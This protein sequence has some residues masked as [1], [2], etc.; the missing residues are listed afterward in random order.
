MKSYL[1][2]SIILFLMIFSPLLVQVT[3]AQEKQEKIV[4]KIGV[5]WWLVPVIAID[6]KGNA[7]TDLKPED[8][9]VKVNQ[10]VLSNFAFLKSSFSVTEAVTEKAEPVKKTVKAPVPRNR[11]VFLLFDLSMSGKLTIQRSKRVAKTI[12][13]DS[14]PGTRFI[15]MSI[16]PF[17]GLRYI[18]ESISDHKQL[19]SQIEKE[20]RPR[21]SK[22]TVAGTDIAV[23]VVGKVARLSASELKVWASEAA[24][25]H[26]RR[27]NAFF[28]SFETLYFHLNGIEDNKFV[29]FFSEGIS[30]AIMKTLHGGASLYRDE[31]KKVAS[32]LGRCGAV[33]FLIN[34]MGVDQYT[35]TTTTA[36]QTGGDVTDSFFNFSGE[37]SL[38]FIA[39]K[40]GG[41]YMEGTSENISQRIQNMH[42]SFYEISFPDIGGSKGMVRDISITSKR[43]GVTI[44][45]IRSIE[46]R[47][48]YDRMNAVEREMLAVNLISS[49]PLVKRK[50]LAFNAKIIKTKKSKKKIVYHVMLPPSFLLKNIDLYKIMVSSKDGTF[51]VKKVEKET[52]YPRRGKFKVEFKFDKNEKDIAAIGTYF[53]YVDPTRNAARIHGIGEYD[54]DMEI[55]ELLERQQQEIT[56]SQKKSK[57]TIPVAELNRFLAGAANYC[58]KVKQSAFHFYCKEGIVETRMPLTSSQRDIPDIGVSDMRLRPASALRNVR[59]KV[60]TKV[61]K[62]EFTYR[63][64]KQGVSIKEER[65]FLSSHDNVKIA[66]NSKKLPRAFHS[67]KAVFAPITLLDRGRQGLYNYNFLR[68]DQ[69][70]GRPAVVIEAVPK[71]PGKEK[72]TVYG[73]I[74]LDKEDFSVLKIEADPRSIMGFEQLKGLA[75]KLRTRLKLSLETEFGLIQNGIRFPTKVS[76]LEKYKGGRL[77]SRYK[78]SAGW[79]RT[80]TVFSYK[81]YRFFD[82]KVDV[83]VQK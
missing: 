23:Q 37:D 40:S 59:E 63:L 58:D 67:Q 25:Y 78:G 69:W 64:I 32:F 39:Q 60:Y 57:E 82:V 48:T 41:K 54:D 13:A 72:F 47:K 62:Y 66:R 56:R 22:R 65:E 46:R 55:M 4:E 7:V 35:S 68:F 24:T 45:S 73:D 3:H 31:M 51:E 70:N 44:V 26:R 21:P 6:K 61:N 83:S 80:R 50:I 53:V 12:I 17:T 30:T 8:I 38:H 15:V 33:L 81:D 71:S 42:R 16:E 2:K 20:I 14:E 28:K 1:I 79:E 29:Y 75:K 19:F 36:Y 43:K 34:T 76:T 74:W 9:Q 52:F 5:N 10:Q 11:V 18:T 27:A 77:I 49:N